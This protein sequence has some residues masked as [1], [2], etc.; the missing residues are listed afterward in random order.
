MST[1][2]IATVIIALLLAAG[3]ASG[4]S[5]P[6]YPAFVASGELPDM[7]MASLPGIRAKQFN[8]NAE[9]RATSSRIDLPADWSGTT[10]A[11]PGKALEVF[12]LDGEL[13]L[14]DMTL[15]RGGYAFLPPGSLGF[16]LHTDNG[17]RILYF[18]DDLAGNAMI[19]TPMI[20]DSGLIE[21]QAT[22][23]IGVL[24]KDLRVDPGSGARTWLLR[25][26]P[27]AQLPWQSTSVVR[28]GYLVTGQFQD[29]ECV[30]GEPYTEIYTAGG[31]FNRPADAVSGGP[32]AS[33]L[34]ESVWFLRES[35]S[36]VINADV[37]CAPN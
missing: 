27:G 19:R 35:S 30:D 33:A 31:Y 18:L 24:S 26:E 10:G 21:W 2:R 29:S 11:S 22:D 8:G 4:P 32:A 25:I 3:C 7:F 13:R 16:N 37:V 12:V 23:T 6:P 34:T 5:S 28:E 1:L 20:L 17:A 36:S 15:R 9:T 14:A